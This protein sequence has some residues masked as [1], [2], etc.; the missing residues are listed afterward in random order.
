MTGP[1]L[2]PLLGIVAGAV[3]GGGIFLLVVAIR[4]LP[5]RPRAPAPASWSR[6]CG[7][8]PAFAGRSPWSWAP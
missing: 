4:G 6:R 1:A 7:T 5:D 3:A 8:W 2:Y